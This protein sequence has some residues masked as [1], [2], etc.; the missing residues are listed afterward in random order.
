MVYTESP[1]KMTDVT[2]KMRRNWIL[3]E[4]MTTTEIREK[5]PIIF[6]RHPIEVCFIAQ[7]KLQ[8]MPYLVRHEKIKKF[9]KAVLLHL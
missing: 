9:N 2:F 5:F 4:K 8:L 7:K 6:L 1:K 3:H